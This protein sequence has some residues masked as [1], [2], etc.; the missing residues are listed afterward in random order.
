MNRKR[1]AP[2]HSHEPEE[3]H[4]SMAKRKH[5]GAEVRLVRARL[6]VL[7]ERKQKKQRELDELLQRGEAMKDDIL[8]LSEAIR[9]TKV[10]LREARARALEE[11]LE[12]ARGMARALEEGNDLRRSEPELPPE[13]HSPDEGNDLEE[14]ND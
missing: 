9:V 5:E 12:E 14:I 13:H 1:K 11:A 2:E 10:T 8:V 4:L 3:N 7:W 6:D